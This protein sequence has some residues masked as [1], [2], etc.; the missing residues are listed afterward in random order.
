LVDRGD[1]GG[2]AAALETLLAR[3]DLAREMGRRARAEAEARFRASAV[4]ARMLDV[5]RLVLA[6]AKGIAPE[7]APVGAAD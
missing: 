4:A 6:E 1:A 5:Y 7:V 3:P 2:L